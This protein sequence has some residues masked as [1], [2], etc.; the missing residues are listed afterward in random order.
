MQSHAIIY[1]CGMAFMRRRR[2]IFCVSKKM[3]GKAMVDCNNRDFDTTI[4]YYGCLHVDNANKKK[5]KN[6]TLKERVDKG[7][8]PKGGTY[9]LPEELQNIMSING[10]GNLNQLNNRFRNVQYIQSGN[11]L[12]SLRYPL[13]CCTVFFISGTLRYFYPFPSI[14]I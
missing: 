13:R 12:N 1:Y 7:K 2:K 6:H 4:M 8:L 14:R 5:L 3:R 10:E 11:Y 9:C